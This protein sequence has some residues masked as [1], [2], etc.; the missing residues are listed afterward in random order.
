MRLSIRNVASGGAGLLCCLLFWACSASAQSSENASTSGSFPLRRTVPSH[1]FAVLKE[2]RFHGTQWG[3]YVYGD[4]RGREGRER[5]CLFLARI[6]KGG[7]F[8]DVEKCGALAPAQGVGEIP[9]YDLLGRTEYLETKVEESVLA[10]TIAPSVVKVRLQVE[11]GKTI[12]RHTSILDKTRQNKGR[13][14][15]LR[16]IALAVAR[17]ICVGRITGYDRGGHVILRADTG[18][19]PLG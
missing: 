18:E 9:V 4:G 7:V 16:Y 1:H 13:V 11:P 12:I 14:A 10:A 17:D 2:A 8:G 6:T 5:P 3:A 15:P 19:C